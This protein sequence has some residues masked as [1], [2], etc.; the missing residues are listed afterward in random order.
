VKE[1]G[2]PA[3]PF[4]VQNDSDDVYRGMS[5]GDYFAGQALNGILSNSALIDTLRPN[6]MEWV[7]DQSLLMADAM[8]AERSKE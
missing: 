8:L 1:D 5:L 3:Y 6:T 4:V 2:G 7:K